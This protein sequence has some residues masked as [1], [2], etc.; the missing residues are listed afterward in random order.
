MSASWSGALI[1]SI[2]VSY[3]SQVVESVQ[4]GTQAT[5]DAQELLVHDGGQ[6]KAAE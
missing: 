4:L 6:G 1:P 5:V 2:G 3:A